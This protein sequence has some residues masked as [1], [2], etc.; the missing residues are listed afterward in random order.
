MERTVRRLAAVLAADVVG[1]SGKIE[2]DESSTLAALKDVRATTVDPLLA[3]NSGR[4]VKT[5]GD[6]FIAEF[7][8]VVD[9]VTFAVA[10]QNSVS[11]RQQGTAPEKRLVY[12]IGINLGDVVVEGD[13][14]LGDGVNVAARLEQICKPGGIL[15]SGTAYDH[16]QGKLGLPLD[17]TGEQQVKNLNRSVRTYAVRLDGSAPS[18]HRALP[19]HLR[20]ARPMIVAVLAAL[21]VVGGSWWYSH[22]AALSSVPSI[23]VMPFE[24]AGG[25]AATDRLARG[26][27]NDISIDF[28]RLRN[29]D[30]IGSSTTEAYGSRGADVQR[31]A[32]DLNVRY[33]LTGAIQREGDQLRVSAQL[34]DGA[35]GASLWSNRWDRPS[36]DIFAVQNEVSDGVIST[37][38]G[39]G[40]LTNLAAVAAKRK[41]PSDLESYDLFALGLADFYKGGEE[42]F[43]EAIKF[44]DA[45]IAKDPQ[46]AFAYVKKAWSLMSY[47]WCS[48]GD[49][50]KT[51]DEFE[52]LAR[53]AIEID[54]YD[55]EGHI[56][57]G[58][59][60][61][62]WG[63]FEQGAVE[64]ERALEL[65]PSSADI[66]AMSAAAMA[67]LGKP[68]EGAAQCDK[69]Y[70]LNSAPPPFYPPFCYESYFF[71]KRYREAAEGTKRYGEWVRGRDGGGD[72]GSL[73]FRAAAGAEAGAADDAAASIV[74][75][76]RRYPDS[77][78]V[79]AYLSFYTAYAR[80]QEPDQLAAS[81]R[82]AGAPM[83][84]PSEQLA[85]IPKLQHLKICDEERAG[86]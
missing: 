44:F 19:R 40:L 22:R 1:Y 48:K 68:E 58:D 76:K 81:L 11:E 53:K 41:G 49:I 7:G 35:T 73:V 50:E 70:R 86:H 30:V 24:V 72:M 85:D 46:F 10:M 18:W 57:L 25:D 56:A 15:I 78:P 5:M 54:P 14:L 63:D 64:V 55:A 60:L 4:I 36:G 29:L 13:D 84:V 67:H 80:Q 6:G 26:I 52:R 82:K 34:Q 38:G 42:G 74:E 66:I 75:W 8:S 59:K 45:T 12:R 9:A 2:A 21:M 28:S 47:S 65:N 79:E 69:A 61:V 71:T 43:A 37:L 33:V 27:A 20:R 17:F 51:G 31:I 23:A 39:R 77:L 32:R 16:L 83:C 62:W 3:E